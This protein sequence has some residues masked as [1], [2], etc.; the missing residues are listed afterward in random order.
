MQ[1]IVVVKWM[2]TIMVASTWSS[3]Q[4]YRETYCGEYELLLCADDD[5]NDGDNDDKTR[6]MNLFIMK[7]QWN[8]YFGQP[9]E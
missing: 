5:N 3:S 9:Q 7:D 8:S 6:S 2:Q 4:A 1:N